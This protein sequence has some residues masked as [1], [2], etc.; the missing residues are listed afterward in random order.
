MGKYHLSQSIR[1]ILHKTT[2]PLHSLTFDND[3]AFAGHQA[4]GHALGL[5]TDVTRPYT[6]Q[7]KETVE[8]R[9]GQIRCSFPKNTD[10]REISHHRVR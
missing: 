1:R 10:L 8:N 5:E 9:I 3:K 2:Y 4:I 7:D 6:S